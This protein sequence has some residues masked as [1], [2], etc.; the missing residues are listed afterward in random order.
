LLLSRDLNYSEVQALAKE[1][2]EAELFRDMQSDIVNQVLR[3][4][5]AIH[6]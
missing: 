5:A 6:V 3:R 1:Q 4:L 2:E